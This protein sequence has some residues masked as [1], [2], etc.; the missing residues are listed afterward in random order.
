MEEFFTLVKNQINSISE[1]LNRLQ[2]LIGLK[3]STDDS[4]HGK[5]NILASKVQD[6]KVP[7]YFVETLTIQDNYFLTTHNP[8][9]E[10]CLND[11]VTL[12]HP[13]DGTLLWEGIEFSENQGILSGAG[14]QF[15]GWQIKVQYFYI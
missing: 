8:L 7:K 10:V 9:N 3:D 1:F 2:V 15:N 5:L 4:I 14:L 13:E 12:Y 11:E 6:I